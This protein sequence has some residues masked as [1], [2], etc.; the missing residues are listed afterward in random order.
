[1]RLSANSDTVKCR[2]AASASITAFS[3]GVNLNL[4]N[5]VFGSVDL[6]NS[7]LAVTSAQPTALPVMKLKL[8]VNGV[9]LMVPAK[10]TEYE[11]LGWSGFAG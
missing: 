10:F 5:S 9:P 11:V 6:W 1:M 8:R 3:A 7:I 4:I 2:A